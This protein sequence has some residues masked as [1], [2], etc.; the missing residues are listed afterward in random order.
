MAKVY[1][2]DVNIFM[3]A[4]GSDHPLKLPCTKIIK[5]IAAREISAVTSA[6]V[7]QEVLHR[8]TSIGKRDVGVNSVRRI[9]TLLS[10][11]LFINEEIILRASELLQ[12]Y[13]FLNARDALHA[14]TMLENNL[15]N[16]LTADTH[17]DKIDE[18]T[19]ISPSDFK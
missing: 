2:I 14:A 17:F 10:P 6:E 3:Y 4:G 18:V 13:S 1:F 11:L 5:L 16:I 9:I 15:T 7:A 8:Y 19:R 12:K